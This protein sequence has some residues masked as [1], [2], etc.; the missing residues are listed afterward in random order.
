LP[1]FFDSRCAIGRLF[2][3]DHIFKAY[4]N[5]AVI[6]TDSEQKRDMAL[7]QYVGRGVVK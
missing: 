1:R 3:S 4:W 6:V 5:G 2:Q 7:R